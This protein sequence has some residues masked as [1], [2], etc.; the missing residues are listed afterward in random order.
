MCSKL[1]IETAPTY[2]LKKEGLILG[3]KERGYLSLVLKKEG[4]YLLKKEGLIIGIKER[5]Y[6]SIKERGFNH[7]Y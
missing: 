6:I 5:G 1:R 4:I 7:W 3:I 2:L